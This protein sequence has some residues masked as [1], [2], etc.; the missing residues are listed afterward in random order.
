MK[1]REVT[2]FWKHVCWWLNPQLE[3]TDLL[4]VCFNLVFPSG[5]EALEVA[6]GS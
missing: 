4:V 6:E 2:V 5:V 1:I 3:M